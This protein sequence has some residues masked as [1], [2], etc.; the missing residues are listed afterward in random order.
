MGTEKL[1]KIVIFDE[2]RNAARLSELV[3]HSQQENWNADHHYT[4]PIRAYLNLLGDVEALVT[5]TDKTHE[6]HPDM[7]HIRTY[8]IDAARD[9]QKLNIPVFELPELRVESPLLPEGFTEWLA[10]TAMGLEQK[11]HLTLVTSEV[12]AA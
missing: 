12:T 10:G 1:P 3:K 8:L 6:K 2:P 11:P 7:P 9:P 4:N 5:S